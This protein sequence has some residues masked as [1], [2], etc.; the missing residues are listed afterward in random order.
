MINSM[1][2]PCIVLNGATTTEHPASTS[3]EALAIFD[4][5]D[6]ETDCPCFI[7]IHPE[8]SPDGPP[9]VITG[10]G[11]TESFFI[12]NGEPVVG[13]GEEE[14]YWWYDNEPTPIPPG[15]LIPKRQARDQL[16]TA[17]GGT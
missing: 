1:A 3:D 17:L 11:A 4:R 5:I 8:G 12:Y 6:R 9:L 2:M 15:I 7:Y 16:A 14:T 10:A 13:H